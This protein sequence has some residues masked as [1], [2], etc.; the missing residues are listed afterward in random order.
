MLENKYGPTEFHGGV[1]WSASDRMDHGI[2]RGV[3]CLCQDSFGPGKRTRQ[4]DGGPTRPLQRENR[5]GVLGE[6]IA[7][8]QRWIGGD[9]A[10]RLDTIEARLDNMETALR[11]ATMGI[12]KGF[13]E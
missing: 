3:D 6:Q 12:A 4:E 10:D 5:S 7:R 1:R 13:D 8:F 9:V 11:D 2:R